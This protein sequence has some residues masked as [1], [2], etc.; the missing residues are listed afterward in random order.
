MTLHVQ[1]DAWQARALLHQDVSC[2]CAGWPGHTRSM[3]G[4]YASEQHAQRADW[5]QYLDPDL[6]NRHIASQA[7]GRLQFPGRQQPWAGAAAGYQ[8]WQGPPPDGGMWQTAE[9][10]HAGSRVPQHLP[11]H[12]PAHQ[13]EQLPEPLAPPAQPL[14]AR[15]HEPNEG[16]PDT[17]GEPQPPWAYDGQAAPGHEPA[18]APVRG[19]K[20]YG[21]YPVQQHQDVRAYPSAPR[22]MQRGATHDSCVSGP[23]RCHERVQRSS[24]AGHAQSLGRHPYAYDQ[25]QAPPWQQLGT[26]AHPAYE[27]GRRLPEAHS[28]DPRF[29]G[30]RQHASMQAMHAGGVP[31]SAGGAGPEAVSKYPAGE[32]SCLPHSCQQGCPSRLQLAVSANVITDNQACN[33]P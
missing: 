26:S 13:P 10:Q 32:L 11:S 16:F 5:N 28:D 27:M 4:H 21:A 7:A 23:G 29:M 19:K 8:Q 15:M 18:W 30:R 33:M 22:P 3:P 2:G 14:H 9:P 24:A 12:T 25:D 6:H 31:R 20:P 17:M 1:E